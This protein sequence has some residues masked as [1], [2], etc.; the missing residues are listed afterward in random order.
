MGDSAPI[1]FS[2]FPCLQTIPVT[3]FSLQQQICVPTLKAFRA[4]K[5]TE[6]FDKAI[7]IIQ[8]KRFY[9]IFC[10]QRGEGIMAKSGKRRIVTSF[11]SNEKLDNEITRICFTTNIKKS[12]LLRA[13]IYDYLGDIEKRKENVSEDDKEKIRKIYSAGEEE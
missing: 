3:I 1:G 2:P 11:E 5:K 8:P 4:E 7:G 12:K 10:S 6:G 9:G 13:A